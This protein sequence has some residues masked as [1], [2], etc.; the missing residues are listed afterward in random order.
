MMIGMAVK[1]KVNAN[2]KELIKN[3]YLNLLSPKL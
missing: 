2:I 1:F 3:M